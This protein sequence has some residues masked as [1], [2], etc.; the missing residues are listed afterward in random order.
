MH[1]LLTGHLLFVEMEESRF[2]MLK[3]VYALYKTSVDEFIVSYHP[4]QKQTDGCNCGF[5]AIAFAAE[6]LDRKSRRE[7]HLKFIYS[8]DKNCFL[9]N[10]MNSVFDGLFF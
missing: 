5:F 3:C 6:V 4:V 10:F 2:A 9:I 8:R 1:P 7:N